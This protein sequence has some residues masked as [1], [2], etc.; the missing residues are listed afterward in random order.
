MLE[1]CCEVG[2]VKK[3]E[4]DRDTKIDMCGWTKKTTEM[5]TENCIRDKINPLIVM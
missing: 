1:A 2:H 5:Q 3:V 4:V